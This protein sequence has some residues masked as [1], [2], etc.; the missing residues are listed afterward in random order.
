M[1]SGRDSHFYIYS[2]PE[3]F[4]DGVP[5]LCPEELDTGKLQRQN[6]LPPGKYWQ[7]IFE[8]QS[9]AWNNWVVEAQ[10]S[11]SVEILKVERFKADPLHDGSWLPEV[12]Q[13]DNA[14]TIS[15]RMWVLF[16]VIKPVDWPATKLG[17][18]TFADDAVTSSDTATN[19]PGPSPVEEIGQAVQSAVD[20]IKP[21][22]WIA[23]IGLLVYEFRKEIFR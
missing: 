5:C 11:G 12:L 9:E 6:P 19:P 10:K 13:P 7:D 14:G 22:L 3:C 2:E 15:A 4:C 1:H 17:F 16:K 21:V 23:G 8:K 18:P 20:S